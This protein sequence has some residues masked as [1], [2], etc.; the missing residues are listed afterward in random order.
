MKKPYLIEKAPGIINAI[1][2]VRT[3]FWKGYFEDAQWIL[4][5]CGLSAT[6]AATENLARHGWRVII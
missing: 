5:N 3:Y 4:E 1:K 2:R 6:K